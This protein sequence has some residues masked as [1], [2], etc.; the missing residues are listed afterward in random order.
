M[1]TDYLAKTREAICRL[2]DNGEYGILLERVADVLCDTLVAGN[3]I[4]LVGNGGSAADCQ[5][6]AGELVGRFRKNRP[7]LAAIALTVDTSILTAC[8]N[9]F[10]ADAVFARQVEALGKE[11]DMLWAYSTSGNSGNILAAC[12]QARSNGMK[13]LGFTG[14]DGGGM[15]D[16]CDFC[17]RA[18]SDITSHIQECHLAAGHLLCLVLEERLSS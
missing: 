7:G 16:I 6:I 9:D 15:K 11:G 13:I 4:L 2:A 17:F 5:H 12:E 8:L 1:I 3:K 10:G 18:P 14:E